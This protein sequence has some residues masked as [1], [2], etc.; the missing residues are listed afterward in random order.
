MKDL[1]IVG[2]GGFGREVAWVVERINAKSASGEWN[3]LGF[4]DDGCDEA[5][6]RV[7]GYPVLG[8]CDVIGNFP[9]AYV[10]C[11]V[12]GA[13]TR[14][15]IIEKIQ[16]VAPQVRFA[17]LIDPSVEMSSLVTVGEGSIICAH[18]I[19]TVNIQVGR[20]V[21]MNLDCTVGHDAV[22][23]DYVTLYPSVNVS[24][25]THLAT[26]CEIGTGSQIIQGKSIGAYAI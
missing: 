12:G 2:A 24:G 23:D 9:D 20:H 21:I 16:A 8:G 13:K 3:L 18:T 10:V 11:A 15:A 4:I 17:T 14:R 22:I 1:L 7:N 6:K 5:D 25:A 26:C 19:L